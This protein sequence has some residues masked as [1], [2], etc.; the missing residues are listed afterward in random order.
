MI[1][2]DQRASYEVHR[3]EGAHAE[4]TNWECR[5]LPMA[6][7]RPGRHPFPV[8][9]VEGDMKPITWDIMGLDSNNVA[10]GPAMGWAAIASTRPHRTPPE[11]FGLRRSKTQL[12]TGG[13]PNS[14]QGRRPASSLRVTKTH[15]RGEP[16]VPAEAKFG[17]V[18]SC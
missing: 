10:V 4:P 3:L 1:E 13:R 9:V 5:D 16:S 6:N 18:V 8:Q 2:R 12:T 11:F 15:H 7:S 14:S 17:A